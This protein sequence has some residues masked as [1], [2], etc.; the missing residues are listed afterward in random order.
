MYSETVKLLQKNSYVLLYKDVG[1]EHNY[2]YLVKRSNKLLELATLF[3][4][5]KYK[6]DDIYGNMPN[7]AYIQFTKLVVSELIYFGDSGEYGYSLNYEK[8]IIGANNSGVVLSPKKESN[9][10]YIRTDIH[11]G[12]GQIS[13]YIGL[14]NG[15]K[16][17]KLNSNIINIAV[18]KSADL[19]KN[20]TNE[21]MDYAYSYRKKDR[22]LS[23]MNQ[24]V[25]NKNYYCGGT[26]SEYNGTDDIDDRIVVAGVFDPEEI[27]KIRTVNERGFKELLRVECG[28]KNPTVEFGNVGTEEDKELR[29]KLWSGGCNILEEPGKKFEQIRILENEYED[30]SKS[31]ISFM[32]ILGNSNN[33]GEI[34]EKK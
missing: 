33:K 7:R 18:Y 31:R 1:D 4:S 22:H 26:F 27:K 8:Q 29:R 5:M 28:I 21:F 17:E 25:L 30:T 20:L 2:N 24:Y 10:I 14:E 16:Y 19:M 34:N 15:K 3:G 6:L 32:E 12:R 11:K 9:N 13:S 23:E